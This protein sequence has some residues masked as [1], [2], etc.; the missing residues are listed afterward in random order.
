MKHKVVHQFSLFG[1]QPAKIRMP[2]EEKMKLTK[3]LR[4]S[5]ALFEA[6]EHSES[7]LKLRRFRE[8]LEDFERRL[9]NRS[10]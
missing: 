8:G 4:E 9:G 2:R 10:G 6:G 5:K 7:V 1:Y 3:L